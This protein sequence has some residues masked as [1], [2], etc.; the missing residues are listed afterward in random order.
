MA[1]SAGGFDAL[2]LSRQVLAYLPSGV[3]YFDRAGHVA[4]ANPA[5]R[6]ALDLSHP[7]GLAAA[8]LFGEAEICESDG[9]RLGAAAALLLESYRTLQILQRK[10]MLYTTPKAQ[11]RR[12][13]ITWFPLRGRRGRPCPPAGLI[14]LLTDLTA[15]HALED[16]L[17]R[18]Q[19][20]SALGEMAAGIAHEFRNGLAVISGYGQMLHRAVAEPARGQAVKILEQAD[21]LN[22]IATEF[23]SFARPLPVEF[24]PIEL[25]PLLHQ[26]IEAIRV[27]EIGKNI[28]LSAEGEFPRVRGDAVLLASAFHNLLRNACEAAADRKE[29]GWVRICPGSQ[30]G[31]AECIEVI[32]NGSGVAADIADNIF[33]PFFTTKT[34]GTGLG[35][36][37]VHKIITAHRGV[38]LLADSRPGHTVFEVRLPSGR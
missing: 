32:D 30:V 38:V 36:A 13:G 15:I 31:D 21:V 19:S 22:N 20:L 6:A 27:Q 25:D 2:R 11:V 18:R 9:T 28:R 3:V 12:L 10:T 14:C 1:Q 7:R 4:A 16:E 17:H 5:A 8:E 24:E 23:L 29:Q 35:L 26:C 34:S 33:V 37:M